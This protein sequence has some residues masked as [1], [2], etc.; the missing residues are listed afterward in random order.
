MQ[1]HSHKFMEEGGVGGIDY[2]YEIVITIFEDD[3]AFWH[4]IVIG[5]WH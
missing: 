2:E 1:I 5:A 3:N 4:N